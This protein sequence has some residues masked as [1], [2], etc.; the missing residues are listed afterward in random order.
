MSAIVGN[1]VKTEFG[2]YLCPNRE[3]AEALFMS[4]HLRER[5]RRP[6]HPKR[7]PEPRDRMLAAKAARH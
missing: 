7:T 2:D 6:L 4:L 1:T 3:Q 5:E